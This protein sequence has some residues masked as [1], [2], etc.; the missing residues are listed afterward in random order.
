MPVC[1]ASEEAKRLVEPL[2]EKR[3][4]KLRTAVSV[5]LTLAFVALVVFVLTYSLPVIVMWPPLFAI[6]YLLTLY[7]ILYPIALPLVPP[8]MAY[9]GYIPA[10]F[11]GL[12]ITIIFWLNRYGMLNLYIYLGSVLTVLLMLML[13]HYLTRQGFAIHR[14]F[15]YGGLGLDL[16]IMTRVA[17][18]SIA[19]LFLVMTTSFSNPELM[20]QPSLSVLI[21][22]S[23]LIGLYLAFSVLGLNVCYRT[24]ELNRKLGTKDFTSKVEHLETD[25]FKKYPQKSETV[26]FLSFILRSAVN[27]FIYGDYARSFLDSY[28]IIHDK[29]IEDPKMIV[30]KML[31]EKTLEEYRRIRVFLVHGILQDKKTKLEI[32][33][34]VKDVVWAR[35]VLFQK[36]LDSIESAF[37][38]ADKI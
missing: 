31:E 36:T 11:F 10:A 18:M 22:V 37:K 26:E 9:Y 7:A 1:T 5:G 29:I 25:L 33:I 14:K 8:W 6:T 24:R 38:I 30:D 15:L 27:D 32:P 19:P 34:Q 12:E 23:S 21:V 13:A 4:K 2:D 35:K 20:N 17:Q 16:K 3:R 28:R